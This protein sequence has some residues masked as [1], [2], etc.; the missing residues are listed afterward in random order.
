MEIAL[1][2]FQGLEFIFRWIHFL[3]GITWIGMLYYMNFAQGAWF[4]ETKPEAKTAAQIGLL[5]RVLWWFR[6]GAMATF[7]SGWIIIF[8]KGAEMGHQ[9]Y[10][11]S[12]GTNIMIGAVLGTLMWANVWFVIWPCQKIVIANAQGNTNPNAAA[13][14]AKTTLAS[15]HNVLFSIALLWFMG[16]ASHLP[17]AMKGNLMT[18]W[19]VILVII[20]ALEFNALKGKLGPLAKVSGV[21]HCGLALALVLY[22]TVV[23]LA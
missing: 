7:V 3:S 13:A 14:G 22:F 8:M 12:W 18:M 20:G 5:P 6:W 21:I 1:F 9:V 11:S 17:I 19:I 16:A 10:L 23:F 4:N 15:R 2:S